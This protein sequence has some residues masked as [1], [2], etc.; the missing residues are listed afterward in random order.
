M[1]YL[2]SSMNPSLVND[3]KEWM[4][5]DEVCYIKQEILYQSTTCTIQELNK[6]ENYWIKEC[7]ATNPKIGYNMRS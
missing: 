7:D 1:K 5:T 3:C 6:Q 4:K 2:G